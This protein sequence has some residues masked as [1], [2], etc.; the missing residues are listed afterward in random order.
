M[1]R[2]VTNDEAEEET[3]V[4]NIVLDLKDLMSLIQLKWVS[5]FR[6]LYASESWRKI[7]YVFMYAIYRKAHLKLTNISPR[8]GRTTT[9]ITS[10]LW[11][12]WRWAVSKDDPEKFHLK[13]FW[14]CFPKRRILGGYELLFLKT[15]P[16]RLELSW[17][18]VYLCWCIF[19]LCIMVYCV[20][21]VTY[22]QKTHRAY[23]SSIFCST[24]MFS[25]YICQE[26]IL[27]SW[28]TYSYIPY[29]A[30]NLD[31][32]LFTSNSENSTWPYRIGNQYLNRKPLFLQ[33]LKRNDKPNV[34]SILVP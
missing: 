27:L 15:L 31:L 9:Y 8:H 23:S 5:Q 16:R 11:I 32:T 29:L 20:V 14:C 7:Y 6:P 1:I 18:R 19:T 17:V 21:K 24:K 2:W 26:Y 22:T 12:F 3:L 13:L 33:R 4:W 28:N 34:T 30:M 10:T 25:V